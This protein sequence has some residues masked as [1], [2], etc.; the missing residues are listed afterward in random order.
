M[1]TS[2]IY[3]V[4]LFRTCRLTPLVCDIA[5]SCING[6]HTSRYLPRSLTKQ[7]PFLKHVDF[8]EITRWHYNFPMDWTPL[9]PSRWVL[10]VI[11]SSLHSIYQVRVL[12]FNFYAYI[13][14]SSLAQLLRLFYFPW[15][16]IVYVVYLIVV[17]SQSSTRHRTSGS[18]ATRYL[19]NR[20]RSK[21]LS[22]YQTRRRRYWWLTIWIWRRTRQRIS[23][24][25]RRWFT[26]ICWWG[27]V[28]IYSWVSCSLFR[29][30][31]LFTITN[32]VS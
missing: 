10:G 4:F 31:P 15:F 25:R 7:W 3:H 26:R 1:L 11:Q 18:K 30:F 13:G 12:F 8:S 32:C 21:S 28:N 24:I 6:P 5:D 16:T 22:K 14:D 9:K 23:T 19:L 27:N 17:R 20:R 2:R 29:S